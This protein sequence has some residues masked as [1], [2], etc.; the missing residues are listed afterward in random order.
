MTGF[1]RTLKASLRKSSELRRLSRILGAQ[2][3]SRVL[4]S[5]EKGL[6]AKNAEEKLFDLIEADPVLAGIMAAHRADRNT[7]RRS[8][9]AL[10]QYGAGEWTKGHW[11]PARALAMGTTLPFVLS[12]AQASSESAWI[13]VANRVFAYF[14]KGE[15]GII[16]VRRR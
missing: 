5:L 16:P 4:V 9:K 11:V 3:P 12:N 6:M 1:L 14:E 2:E 8:Y 10:C 15:L 7:L 13:E